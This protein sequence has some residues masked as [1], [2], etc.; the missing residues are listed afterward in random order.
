MALSSGTGGGGKPGGSCQRY[1]GASAPVCAGSEAK[2]ESDA[3]TSVSA[4]SARRTAPA[5]CAERCAVACRVLPGP[6]VRGVAA[7]LLR[8]LLAFLDPLAEGL[9]LLRADLGGRLLEPAVHRGHQEPRLLAV[10]AE[11]LDVRAL[12]VVE[13]RE[14]EVRLAHV[15]ER[16]RVLGIDLERASVRRERLL[17]VTALPVRVA[18]V[19][20]RLV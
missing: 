12:H 13:A 5:R 17:V 4:Q 7:H 6:R 1:A 18:E 15:L 2:P 9:E 8:E 16:L 19:A 14:L 11:E 10:H 3:Q 20:V